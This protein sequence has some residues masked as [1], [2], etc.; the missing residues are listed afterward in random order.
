VN[1][2]KSLAVAC[3]CAAVPAAGQS[4]NNEFGVWAGFSPLS[5]T[6]IGTAP[7]R[8][9]AIAALRY[10]RVLMRRTRVTLEYTVDAVPAAILLQ[11]PNRGGSRSAVYGFGVSPIGWKLSFR[12][13]ARLQPFL[14]TSGGFVYSFEPIPI[15]I[16]GATQFNFTFHFGAGLQYFSSPHRSL[17]AGYRLDHISNANRTNVN[18]GVDANVIFVGFSFWK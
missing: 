1:L 10:G 16:P 18:P 9:Y 14:S 15:N 11:P 12:P 2:A 13:H 4:G 8:Q 6:I 5:P 3:L 7:D 17:S